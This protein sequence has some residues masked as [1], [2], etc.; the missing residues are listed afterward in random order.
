MADINTEIRLLENYM[1]APK[2]KAGVAPSR[3]RKAAQAALDELAILRAM[4]E[5]LD[6]RAPL[7]D[8]TCAEPGI[9]LSEA[10]RRETLEKRRRELEA[11]A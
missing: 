10:L 7:A 3:A 11:T 4:M 5:V 9:T 6:E 8:A 2:G 1:F